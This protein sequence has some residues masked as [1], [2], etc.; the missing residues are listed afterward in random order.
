MT[1]DQKHLKKM[2][3]GMAVI[4]CFS[5]MMHVFL[6]KKKALRVHRYEPEYGKTPGPAAT[7]GI[8][9]GTLQ[10]E[11]VAVSF[12]KFFLRSNDKVQPIAIGTLRMPEVGQVLTI[13]HKGGEV[14]EAVTIAV[15]FDPEPETA[16]TPAR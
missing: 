15:D 14:P 6:L 4:I 11:V 12:D 8:A 7:P 13:T 16:A 10:G 1:A 3:I 9:A 2:V 5:A